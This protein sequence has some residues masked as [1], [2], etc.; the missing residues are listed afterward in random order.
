MD[1]SV[2][3]AATWL[4]DCEIEQKRQQSIWPLGRY[5]VVA[6]GT[7]R[8]SIPVNTGGSA[9]VITPGFVPETAGSVQ[10]AIHLDVDQRYAWDEPI[11]DL[12]AMQTSVNA[13]EAYVQ[14]AIGGS[15]EA[16]D[17]KVRQLLDGYVVAESI[18]ASQI[19]TSDAP[20]AATAA[21]IAAEIQTL[22][23]RGVTA[24]QTS[25]NIGVAG[26]RNRFALL[27]SLVHNAL[28]VGGGANQNPERPDLP[29]GMIVAE[30]LPVLGTKIYNAGL[31]TRTHVEATEY[32]AEHT[33]IKGYMMLPSAFVVG[34][35]Q[36]PTI[37]VSENVETRVTKL[38]TTTYFGLS[39]G[40]TSQ[41]IELRIKIA[42][43]LTV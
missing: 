15:M 22:I 33:V 34:I 43:D 16:I 18:P 6:P 5:E 3:S 17:E 11:D 24:L 36:M 4:K 1:L 42:G 40:L 20:C 23:T 7:K 35:Q 27:D 37:K 14:A 25:A 10:S 31:L 41:F 30:A 26:A 13:R 38:C 32:E 9:K 19:I 21:G 2:F 39:S 8:T 12:E 28:I 29:F